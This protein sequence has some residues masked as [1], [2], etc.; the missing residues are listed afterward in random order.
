M[1]VLYALCAHM[2]NMC[3]HGC[4][5]LPLH[6]Q[7]QRL[8]LGVHFMF[9]TKPFTEPRAH[10]LAGLAGQQFLRIHWLCPSNAEATMWAAVPNFCTGA[11]EPNLGPH[12]C[13][14]GTL[15][16]FS[17]FII[18]YLFCDMYVYIYP[19]KHISICIYLHTYI[20]I[21]MKVIYTCIYI[22]IAF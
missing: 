2:C 13:A 18:H 5:C 4:P 21:D 8:M 16:F 22:Y 1:C 3:V 14:V 15:P 7:R 11:R 19:N 12:M 9:G 10:S 20:S 17:V 6:V